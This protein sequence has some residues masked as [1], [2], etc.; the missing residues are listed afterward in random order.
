MDRCGPRFVVGLR[1]V[2]PRRALP[3]LAF[4]SGCA[5]IA[6]YGGFQSLTSGTQV[7]DWQRVLW[8]ACVLTAPTALLSGMLFTQL[9]DAIRAAVDPDTRAAAWLTVANTTG[10][11]CGA[12]LAGFVLLPLLGMERAFFLLAILYG[13]IGLL[14]VGSFGIAV[15][16]RRWPVAIGV[17][18]M[19]LGA[20]VV[21]VWS[22]EGSVLSPRGSCIR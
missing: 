11:L 17:A 7:G 15:S 10:A 8:F 6:S 16:L 18:A 22:H 19:A 5:V 20:S 9:G 13:V 21:S 4:A 1:K 12:P 3:F 2:A 14:V